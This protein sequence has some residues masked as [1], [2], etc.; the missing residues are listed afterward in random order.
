MTYNNLLRRSVWVPECPRAETA[1]PNCPIDRISSYPIITSLLAL[2]FQFPI[3]KFQYAHTVFYFWNMFSITW[4]IL[5]ALLFNFVTWNNICITSKEENPTGMNLYFCFVFY[6]FA[7][8]DIFIKIINRHYPLKET[9]Y[10][11][12][13]LYYGRFVWTVLGK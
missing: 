3:V 2:T 13:A 12:Y 8:T 7:S 9:L 1:A 10:C 11:K 4:V 6:W 5:D